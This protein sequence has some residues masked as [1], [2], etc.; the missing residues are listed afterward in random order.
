MIRSFAFYRSLSLVLRLSSIILALSVILLLGLTGCHGGKK[1]D[2]PA[3]SSGYTFKVS[4]GTL[5]DSTDPKGLVVLATLRDSAGNGPGGAAG[6]QITITGPGIDTPLVVDYD[7]GSPS[8]YTTWWW[9]N[10]EPKTGTYTASA[11]NDSFTLTG[12]FT[13]D[14]ASCLLSTTLSKSGDGTISW[15]TV[16]DA[17]SYYYHL[18]D[19]NGTVADSGYLSSNQIS[20]VL[21]TLPDGDYQVEVFAHTKN[22]LELMT[23]SSS[24]PT[25]PTHENMSVSRLS[26]PVSGVGSGY[27]LNTSGGV[28]YMGMDTSLDPAANQ[29]G[30]AVWTSIR[31]STDGTAPAGD[32]NVTVT[33]PGING[34]LLFT[35]PA[36]Y[37]HYLY[38]D[39][40]SVP[41]VGLYTVAATNGSAIL[42]DSFTIPNTIS[43][44]PVA[45]GIA[46]GT[47][48]GG[49]S[50]TWDEVQGASSYYLNLWTCVGAGSKNTPDGC[51]AGGQYAEIAG[52]WVN[53]ASA[54]VQNSTLANGFVYDVYVTASALDM[55]T[56]SNT[57]PPTPGT[58]VDMSDT[59]YTYYTFTA[60]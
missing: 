54:F 49:Y 7:D 18:T 6:W 45:T 21:P 40:G 26:F 17:G 57:P 58:Q 19:G 31:A 28:L 46:A 25:L 51:T 11:S 55:T 47:A 53:T 24:A 10:I 59:T 20:F 43:Q 5:N 13:I 56:T 22:R 42:T 50:V 1:N 38:W 41:G 37:S 33:G 16:T 4:G 34:S 30:L 44:L 52:G 48:S 27:Y 9:K 23:D 8:S 35:Y 15:P 2:S 32:W 29:Y 39:F 3:S 36:T 60:H 14:P 12:S